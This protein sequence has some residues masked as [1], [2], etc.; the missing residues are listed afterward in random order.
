MKKIVIITRIEEQKK[1]H[2]F[3]SDT[4]QKISLPNKGVGLDKYLL[5]KLDIVQKERECIIN[6]IISN[7]A[8]FEAWAIKNLNFSGRFYR[9]KTK[10]EEKQWYSTTEGE[11]FIDA[12]T[13][14]PDFQSEFTEKL[15]PIQD[16]KEKLHKELDVFKCKIIPL[17]K[18]SKVEWFQ[19]GEIILLPCYEG[20]KQIKYDP[21]NDWNKLITA[22][23]DTF[24]I[25]ED[26]ENY[27]Y[28]HDK[29]CGMDSQC[30]YPIPKDDLPDD[31]KKYFGA[32]VRIFSHSSGSFYFTQV[33]S[34]LENLMHVATLEE[35]RKD[36][37]P[38]LHGLTGEGVTI[39]EIWKREKEILKL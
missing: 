10:L 24:G 5:D 26:T 15:K 39:E 36:L 4:E 28:I 30:G 37:I 22:I 17:S 34:K 29:E 7:F 6:I 9:Y 13:K 14:L 21:K 16:E 2:L 20:E 1:E 11:S 27:L 33:L 35:N 12:L 32:N 38:P 25:K 8:S 23:V 18:V 19:D 3:R 31:V